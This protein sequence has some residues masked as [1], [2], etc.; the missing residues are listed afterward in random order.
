MMTHHYKYLSLIN[1]QQCNTEHHETDTLDVKR[2]NVALNFR[3]CAPT[4]D[5]PVCHLMHFMWLF[6]EISY[7]SFAVLLSFKNAIVL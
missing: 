7:C 1:R 4:M 6:R 2:K 3:M 5:Q